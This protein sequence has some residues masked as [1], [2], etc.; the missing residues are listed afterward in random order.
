MILSL[1]AADCIAQEYV[2]KPNDQIKS[3]VFDN[4]D[5]SVNAAVPPDGIIS[6]PLVGEL[7]VLGKTARQLEVMLAD[8]LSYYI[9]NPKVSVQISAYNPLKIYLIG[10][11]R[12]PGSY[13]YKPENRFVD[14]LSEA[15]GF[16]PLK[17]DIKKCRIYSAGS[18]LR[19]DIDL[20]ELFKADSLNIGYE[21]K[22]FDTIYLPEKSGFSFAEWRDVAD[23]INIILGVFTLYLIIQRN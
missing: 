16:D 10:A 17:A 1:T 22:P 5:I 11:F 9:K 7:M 12:N 6:F 15:G 18:I 2:I 13:N 21:L 8:K 14:Y 20:K 23:A 4:P 19:M 3:S